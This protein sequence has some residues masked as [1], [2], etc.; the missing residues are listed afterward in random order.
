MTCV[1][2]FQASF[3]PLLDETNYL[4]FPKSVSIM[5]LSILQQKNISL[6][7]C[8]IYSEALAFYSKAFPFSPRLLKMF[9]LY[10][11]CILLS[12]LIWTCLHL[13][14]L[15]ECFSLFLILY[16]ICHCDCTIVSQYLSH[17]QFWCSVCVLLLPQIQDNI[18]S[19]IFRQRVSKSSEEVIHIRIYSWNILQTSL[20]NRVRAF[21]N[22]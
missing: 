14:S 15:S 1:T 8:W 16:C 6:A 9:F 11:N 22:P 13:T 5:S 21:S 10:C 20:K 3:S 2:A 17:S 18:L 19:V 7:F 12:L 4:F